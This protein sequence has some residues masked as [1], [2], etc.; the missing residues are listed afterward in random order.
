MITI[1]DVAARAQVSIATVSRVINDHPAVN[2][3]IR[4]VVL[5]A[6]AELQYQPNPIARILRTAQTRTLGLL[7]A[8]IRSPEAA[9]A[10]WGAEAVAHE[11]GYALLVADARLHGATGVQHLRSLLERRID[12]LLCSS[13][14]P[15]ETVHDFV[16]R[17]GV[18][19]VVYG[20]SAPSDLLPTTVLSYTAATEEAVD[21]L[22]GL[23]HRRIGAITRTTEGGVDNR[24]G[25][26]QPYIHHLLRERG[27]ETSGG[28]DRAASSPAECS[29]VVHG[30]L[31][32]SRRPT[33]LFV[34]SPYLIPATLAAIRDA[35]ARV[36]RD[37]SVIG[38][39]D[40]DWG[41][42]ID[43]PL[44][45]IA[46]DYAAH[47]DAAARLLVALIEEEDSPVPLIEHHGRYIRRG[48]V[49]P[50]GSPAK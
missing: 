33:A 14:V 27:I 30:L 2:P 21:H 45:V 11:R 4:R 7:V 9:A 28:L 24:M 48:S 38:Y 18:P 12:G 5:E 3:A 50:P 15:V 44:N 43:P 1:R 13:A 42:L 37:V 47:L 36:P 39:G 10:I 34:T 16:E 31:T 25:T 46:V 17:T 6:I 8:D 41:R 49:G 35:G 22:V 20:R 29:K 40:P 19:A 26:L 23:G 32:G